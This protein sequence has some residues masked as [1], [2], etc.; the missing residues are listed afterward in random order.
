MIAAVIHIVGETRSFER[1]ELTLR[2]L[3]GHAPSPPTIERLAHQIGGEWAALQ[4]NEV[5]DKDV[6]VPEVSVVSCDGGRIRTRA[7]NARPGVHAP[8]WRETKNSS[9]ERMSVPT[10][11]KT[12]PCPRLPKTF[13]RVAYVAQMADMAAFS[14]VP[15]SS[16][17]LYGSAL[18]TA[19]QGALAEPDSVSDR[20]RLQPPNNVPRMKYQEYRQVGLPITTAWMESLVKEMGYRVEGTELFWNDPDGGEA[21]LQARAATLSDDDRLSRHVHHGPPL[22]V[23]PKAPK[24]QPSAD[25][26]LCKS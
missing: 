18:S 7:A 14:R 5:S 16:R 20:G 12:D 21:I 13:R 17:R 1:T 23:A 24:S 10:I 22:L 3:L 6:V 4:E 8:A 2:Y 26:R 11:A 15:G 25:V 9:F 19:D